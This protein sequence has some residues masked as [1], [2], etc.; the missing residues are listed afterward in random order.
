MF[1][2]ISRN[3]GTK[4]VLSI[5]KTNT[6]N[7]E[8]IIDAIINLGLIL[9]L[10]ILIVLACLIFDIAPEVKEYIFNL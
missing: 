6:M 8:K 3:P 9:I 1:Q 10:V 2:R 7:K 5:L 4:N